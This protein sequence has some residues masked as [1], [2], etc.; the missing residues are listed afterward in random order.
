M[1]VTYVNGFTSDGAQAIFIDEG[2]AAGAPN[3]APYGTV[4]FPA[5][6]G[7][8]TWG[9]GKENTTNLPTPQAY[10]VSSNYNINTGNFSLNIGASQAFDILRP[11]GATTVNILGVQF[12]TADNTPVLEVAV[13]DTAQFIYDG[14]FTILGSS[15]IDF[16]VLNTVDFYGE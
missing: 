14:E 11:S 6:G 12:L 4:G 8:Q 1:A 9:Y 15:T 16:A 2:F 13:N 5:V 7:G 10:T 3:Y